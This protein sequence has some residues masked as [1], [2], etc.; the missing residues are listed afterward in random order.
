MV[1]PLNFLVL[2]DPRLV[3]LRVDL[4]FKVMRSRFWAGSGNNLDRFAR[5][6][7]RIHARCRNTDSLLAAAHPEPMKLRPVEKLGENLRDLIPNDSRTVVDYRDSEPARL[8]YRRRRRRIIRCDFDL[9]DD[10]RKNSRLLTRIQRVVD[11]FL[12]ARQERFSR[13]IES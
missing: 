3:F 11:G 1:F 9:D 6:E 4:D 5:R 2:K 10:F 8:A 7:L 13:I 12:D